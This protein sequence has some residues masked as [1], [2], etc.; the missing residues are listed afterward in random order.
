MDKPST[1]Y[2]KRE[3]VQHFSENPL[4]LRRQTWMESKIGKCILNLIAQCGERLEHIIGTHIFQNGDCP[5]EE[6]GIQNNAKDVAG[7]Q[8]TPKIEFQQRISKCWFLN[9]Q[10]TCE[11]KVGSEFGLGTLS[12]HLNSPGEMHAQNLASNLELRTYR[13]RKQK[14]LTESILRLRKNLEHCKGTV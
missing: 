5:W 2:L 14:I 13:G 12:R 3:D 7:T 6:N 4:D 10:N 8:N 11:E 1:K 9:I